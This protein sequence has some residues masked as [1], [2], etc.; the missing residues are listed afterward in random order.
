M[1][2][3]ASVF[4]FTSEVSEICTGYLNDVAIG[5]ITNLELKNSVFLCS[6]VKFMTK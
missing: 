3:I 2:M 4:I 1:L 6:A 5:T